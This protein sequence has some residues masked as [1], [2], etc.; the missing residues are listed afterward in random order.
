VAYRK[1]Y[2]AVC[3]WEAVLDESVNTQMV[4]API[5]KMRMGRFLHHPRDAAPHDI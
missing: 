5:G 2:A 4:W 1:V 3:R